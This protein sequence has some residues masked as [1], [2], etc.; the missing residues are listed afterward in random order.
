MNRY[1]SFACLAILAF[2]SCEKTITVNPPAHTPG[3]AV[4]SSSMTGSA[5]S[6][7]ISRTVAAKEYSSSRDYTLKNAV[8][9]LSINGQPADTLDFNGATGTYQSALTAQEGNSYSIKVSSPGYADV[10]AITTAPVPV[11]IKEVRRVKEA[12][13]DPDGNLQDEITLVFDDPAAAADFYRIRI[14]QALYSDTFSFGLDCVNTVDPSVETFGSNGLDLYS[15]IS[16]DAIYLRDVLFNGKTK[17]LRIF[18]SSWAMMS[19]TD[20]QGVEHF[21]VIELQHISDDHFKYLKS[22]KLADETNGNPF[23]EPVNV[24]SNIRN[25]YGIFSITSRDRKEIK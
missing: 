9:V 4:Q 22:A 7:K 12:R 16:G 17:E 5:F 3:I 25:G 23:A 8:A 10:E 11:G 19:I 18:V 2:A 13:V 6:M 15:C 21:P 1:I 14:Q 24:H 20:N